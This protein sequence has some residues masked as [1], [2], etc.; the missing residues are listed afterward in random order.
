MATLY[1][2]STETFVGK[3]AVCIGLLRRMQRDGFHVGYMKPVSVSVAHT[4]G[5]VVDEDATFIRETIGLEAPIEKIA[6]VLITPSVVEAILRGQS[7]SYTRTLRDA[8]LAVSR[9][10]DIV[11]LEGTNTWSEGSL[12]NLTSD[13]VTDLLQA[14]V[15][16]VSQY[17]STIN[18]DN[19]LSVQRYIGDRLLG[20]LI[21][22]IEEAQL[23]FV[24]QRVV[25]YL[26]GRG[27]PVFGLLPR[28]PMLAGISIAELLDH[29]GG[30]LIG[31]R[32]WCNH[33]VET[34]MIGAM[35]ADASLSFFRRRANK[36]VITGGD[37]SDLQLAALETSTNVL[38]LTGNFRP[39]PQV[40][41]RAEEKEVPI[42]LVPDDTLAT[43]DRAER[44]FGRVR[45][46]QDA[47]LQRFAELMDTCFAYDRLYEA[48]GLPG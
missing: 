45:F 31:Q 33:T 24:Q 2:A 35:G 37:R 15:L 30:Q 9:N 19:I 22:Q 47:K 36:A 21:N 32:A 16:L 6:P 20:V 41:D 17:G 28:D 18:V 43:V 46:H 5:A 3:S 42:I 23:E 29:L 7:A 40:I 13:Q 27:I 12:V 39:S 34:L 1:V 44:L 11:V 14:P 25:P 48:L 4:P 8:Y 38:V 26:E 10:K